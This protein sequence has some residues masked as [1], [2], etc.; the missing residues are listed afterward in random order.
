[1]GISY[2]IVEKRYF[3]QVFHCIRRKWNIRI[4]IIP[5]RFEKRKKSINFIT[6]SKPFKQK[7]WDL[8]LF[9]EILSLKEIKAFLQKK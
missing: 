8:K 2:S 7:F 6:Y 4:K 5:P 3:F 1:M 9:L